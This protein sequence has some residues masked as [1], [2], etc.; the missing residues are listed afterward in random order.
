MNSIQS[1]WEGLVHLA[2]CQLNL[3]YLMSPLMVQV[4]ICIV[5]YKKDT[6]LP[7]SL[8]IGI[9]S[10]FCFKFNAC[11]WAVGNSFIS[12]FCCLLPFPS[13]YLTF[14]YF[15]PIPFHRV[16]VPLLNQLGGMDEHCKLRQGL[17]IESSRQTHFGGFWDKSNT[18]HCIKHTNR[19]LFTKMNSNSSKH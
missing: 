11:F 5:S 19:P 16:F 2:C 12:S 1:Q 3:V 9:N 7:S 10:F 6:E 18:L 15:L 17:R 8:F 13:P 14:T 4:S